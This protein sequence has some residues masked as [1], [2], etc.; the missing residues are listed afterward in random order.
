M[1]AGDVPRTDRDLVFRMSRLYAVIAVIVC[2]G[3]SGALF[4]RPRPHPHITDAFGAAIL[5]LLYLMHRFVTS[6]FHP[7]NWLVRA[8]DVGLYI[9]FRSYLNERLSPGDPTVV[10]L[11]YSAMRSARLVREELNTVDMQG[12]KQAQYLKWIELELGIDP[13]PLSAALSEELGRP[14][15][16]EEHWYGTSSTLYQDYPVQMQTPPFLRVRWQVV[17]GAS[18][19]LD[20]LKGRVEVAPKVKVKDDFT[21]LR[22]LSPADQEKRLRQLSQRGDVI[23]AVY[24]A[25]KLYGCT[26]AEATNFVKG[27]SGGPPS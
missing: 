7:S 23:S 10:F 6:R 5:L 13:A 9:H 22:S 26:L 21:Q 18:V 19:F 2:L 8:G 25:Q 4:F 12:A 1:R 17:P 14:A 27:L 20:S 16:A 24:T 15:P 3:A 11:P